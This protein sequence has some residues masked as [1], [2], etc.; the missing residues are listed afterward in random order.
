MIDY[1]KELNNK[2]YEAVLHNNSPL[3]I[4][5]G[6]GSG[7]T[8]TITY[9][10]AYL[11]E[12]KLAQPYNILAI[13]F[14]NKAAE[15]MR[16]RVHTL[17]QDPLSNLWI[18]TFHSTALAIL[19]FHSEKLGYGKN[20]VI[21]DE[22]DKKS[23]LRKCFKEL[24]LDKSQYSLKEITS[25]IS[26]YKN[27][28]K[29]EDFWEDEKYYEMFKLY[30]HLKK[31][32]NVF[33]FDDL[34][35]K[36]VQLFQDYPDV[37]DYYKKRWSYILIDEYQDV[38]PLQ[39]KFIQLLTDKNSYLTVVGDDDQS[40]YSWR[41]S[42]PRVFQQF[43]E[44]YDNVEI[45]ILDQNYRSTKTIIES[46]SHLISFNKHRKEK[47]LWTNNAKGEEIHK[48]EVLNAFEE[49]RQ[50][51]VKVQE[52][53]DAGYSYDDMAVFYRVNNQSQFIENILIEEKMP[54]KI[55]GGLKFFERMEIKDILA[56][57]KVLINHS[58]TNSLLRIINKPTRGIGQTSINK[59]NALA[60]KQNKS[61]YS[62]LES[63]ENFDLPKSLKIKIKNFI[64][65]MTDFQEKKETMDIYELANYISDKIQY[66]SFLEKLPLAE[67][68]AKISNLNEFFNLLKQRTSSAPDLTIEEYLD[69]LSLYTAV[70]S[71]NYSDN[72]ITLMTLHNAKGLEFPIV[73][74]I[75]VEE[76]L[77]PHKNALERGTVDEERR[78]FYVG[79]TRAK[80]K[81]F[82]F[83]VQERLMYGQSSI[84]EPSGFLQQIRAQKSQSKAVDR[85]KK[86]LGKWKVGDI[87][88]HSD[89]GLGSIKK[90]QGSGED[91]LLIIDFESGRKKFI[92]KFSGLKKI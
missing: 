90:I 11:L 12:Q 35:E 92:Q 14:T 48:Y 30:E 38:N 70:D 44:D 55:V 63:I 68:E 20:F 7:K 58:D 17:V 47:K 76:G 91:A 41:G 82:L 26:L 33:D 71:M 59:L 13:T 75:G 78:L 28:M 4:F 18:R 10:I 74:I 25:Q 53:Y 19:K 23:L 21:Y 66:F 36:I 65:L 9:K 77:L 16:N 86:K 54:Y 2:Q 81:L 3:L 80:E 8:R 57:L 15:E 87:V 88:K 56:Y 46:A 79:I 29:N 22:Q 72:K 67:R 5:A 50:V 45:V 61:F 84:A 60:N 64:L 73:F 24:N 62:V 43:E 6:A 83:Y 1:K 49:A 34:L 52:L 85:N 51:L 31:E 32:Y 69:E 27:L 42:S 89:Y 40:I 37:R 39:Y